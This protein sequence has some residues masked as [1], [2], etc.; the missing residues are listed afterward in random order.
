MNFV[1]IVEFAAMATIDNKTLAIRQERV[2][3][4]EQILNLNMRKL[5]AFKIITKCVCEKEAKMLLFYEIIQFEISIGFA[6]G[7]L[8]FLHT[9]HIETNAV[10]SKNVDFGE[11]K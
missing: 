7:S 8:T 9:W 5:F 11:K 4:I 10:T 2:G 6:F 3:K 1:H